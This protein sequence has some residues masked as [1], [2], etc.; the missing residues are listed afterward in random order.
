[1]WAEDGAQMDVSAAF[2][3]GA[4]NNGGERNAEL[5][6]RRRRLGDRRWLL[7]WDSVMD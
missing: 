7:G 3:R 6:P 5:A 2:D 1:M 4:R